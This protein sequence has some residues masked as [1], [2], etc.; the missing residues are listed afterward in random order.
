MFGGIAESYH[1]T[2]IN[3]VGCDGPR[4]FTRTIKTS[5]Y[6][7]PENHHLSAAQDL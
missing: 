2:R 1:K 6:D 4:H 3:G 5:N 7:T